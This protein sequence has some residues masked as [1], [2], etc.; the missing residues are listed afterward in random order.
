MQHATV[1][2]HVTKTSIALLVG[3]TDL[4][5]ETCNSKQTNGRNFRRNCQMLPCPN[6]LQHAD[7]QELTS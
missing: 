5:H 3:Q 4:D 1:S 2:K 6:H 7:M